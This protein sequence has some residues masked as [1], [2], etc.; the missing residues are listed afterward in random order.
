MEKAGWT[1]Q[2][3]RERSD[4]GS[5]HLCSMCGGQGRLTQETESKL[6]LLRRAATGDTAK[7]HPLSSLLPGRPPD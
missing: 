6:G 2:T 7:L 4:T 3:P 5:C 1:W